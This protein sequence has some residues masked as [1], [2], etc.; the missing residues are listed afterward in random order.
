MPPEGAEA[1][2]A[3]A[4]VDVVRAWA[5]VA[6]HG[7]RPGTAEIRLGRVLRVGLTGGIGSGKST[8]T[9]LL[10]ARGA[11]IVDADLIARAVVAPG[12]P[13]LA[14][15]VSAFGPEALRP[16]GLLDREGL[17][18]R[19]FADPAALARLNAIVHPLVGA[20]SARQLRAAEAAGAQ[21]VVHDVPL[22][23]ENDLQGEYDA[24]VVVSA[25]PETA[26]HRLVHQRGLTETDARA[27][28]AAQ[29][30]LASKL[31]VATHVI[32]N[33][34]PLEELAGQVDRLWSDLLSVAA[35]T[36]EP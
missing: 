3:A 28:V 33:D 18:R 21:V 29:L 27:R 8:V 31:A 20:E 2:L 7:D 4:P 19:V 25:Q 36:V 5:A 24:V 32:D 35:R 22:L 14:A 15:V 13:G 1:L 9:A 10:A 6:R 23:V 26:L 11:V 12:T 30:P 17:G 16:D 34:G